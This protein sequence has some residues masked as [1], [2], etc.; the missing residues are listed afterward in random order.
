ML[1]ITVPAEEV[2]DDEKEEFVSSSVFREWHLQLEHSLVSLSKWERKWHKPFFSKKDKTLPEI[3]DYI[4]CMTITKSVPPEVY[5]RISKNQKLID[6]ISNYID[7]PMTATTFHN[8]SS[9]HTSREIITA[10][11][12]YY[13]MISY[14]IPVEFEK[15]HINSLLTL[16]RVCNIKNSPGKK[17]SAAEIT[18]RN[19]AL[20]KA[21][22]A[23]HHSKG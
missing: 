17:L 1:E 21:R 5:D 3:I 6:T 4:K 22:R 15:W 14:G 18:R 13:W 8:E 2:W 9:K 19:E 12:I 20:N 16:I 23:R 10:E 11:L 7:D